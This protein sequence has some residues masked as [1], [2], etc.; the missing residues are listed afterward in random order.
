M[1]VKVIIWDGKGREI[2]QWD[3]PIVPELGDILSVDGLQMRIARIR[4]KNFDVY[5]ESQPGVIG[6]A[7]TL[8][9]DVV[10]D[11]IPAKE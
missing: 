7:K 1:N 3:L 10:V 5:L 2:T 4:R 11:L 9:I 8:H 6:Q